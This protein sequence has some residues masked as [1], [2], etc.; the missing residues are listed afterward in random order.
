MRSRF[1]IIIL[2]CSWLA[3]SLLLF[4]GGTW[5]GFKTVL[6]GPS[7][8]LALA[9]NRGEQL[10]IAAGIPPRD[11]VLLMLTHPTIDVSDFEFIRTR[12]SLWNLLRNAKNAARNTAER[13]NTSL[14]LNVQTAGHNALDDNLFFSTDRKH[15]LF[16]AETNATVDQSAQAL[17]SFP[18]SIKQWSE[19]FPGFEIHYL[20]KGLGDNEI[21]ALIN[22]DLDRSLI[23]TLPLSLLVLFWTFGSLV[24]TLI[25]LLFALVSLIAALGMTAIFSA[26]VSPVSA[27]AAQL[28][29]LL[30]LAIGVDYSL[31]IISR[32]REEVQVGCTYL[33]AVAI[34]RQ[35]AGRAVVLSG[36]T[37]ALSLLGLLLMQDSIL[38]SM[39]TVSIAATIITVVSCVTVLPSLLLILGPAI[40]YGRIRR[41]AKSRDNSTL[42]SLLQVSIRH[43]KSVMATIAGLLLGLSYFSTMIHLGSTV[44]PQTLPNS[45][46]LTQA[47]HAMREAFPTMVGSDVSIILSAADISLREQDGTIQRFLKRV[48]EIPELRGPV[49]VDRSD[50]NT[51]VR[52]HFV[53]PG[54]INDPGA[55]EAI[56]NIRN[57]LVPEVLRAAGVEAHLGGTLPYAVDDDT[58]Y[59]KKTWR[60]YA[61]ILG[62]SMIFLLIA[63]RSIVV[64]I[65]AILLNLFSTGAAFG[66]MVIIFQGTANINV[67]RDL[68]YGVIESFVPA[69]LFAILFGLSMDY[70]VFLLS[71]VREEILHG[72]E[73]DLA[74][75]RA[76]CTTSKTITSAALIMVSVFSI[77]ATLELPVMKQLGIGLAV[78]I[79]LDATVVRSLL[80][81]A[82]LKLLGK[83]NWYLPKGL[84]WLPTISIHGGTSLSNGKQSASTGA[85]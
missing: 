37:V 48:S 61:T 74:I 49:R 9:E 36:L 64:P 5:L 75:K 39:A 85:S 57:H 30:V 55:H 15:L 12:D 68:N 60:V 70:H 41:L 66:I 77:I 65:K 18:T 14:F 46:Q 3:G 76:L 25:P 62:L 23:F 47:F 21:F 10:A 38:T 83:W 20:S 13:N 32:M 50:N 24:A 2:I 72:G 53:V 29:V 8:H 7:S 34:S 44:Q 4:A 56:S 79:L 26:L 42:S 51:V 59:G 52:Y 69:L 22:R 17:L 6:P 16:I 63:F 58:R 31:F 35:T 80:L 43:P 28:V 40:E 45:L 81:P 11:Q 1:A 84:S 67:F 33:E 19:T 54:K 27:T 71:R 78:A 82:S 73:T